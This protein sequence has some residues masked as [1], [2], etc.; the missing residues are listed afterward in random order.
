MTIVGIFIMQAVFI[1]SAVKEMNITSLNGLE[2]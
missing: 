2:D 1:K